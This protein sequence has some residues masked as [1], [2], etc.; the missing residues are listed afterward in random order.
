MHG[1]KVP[2]VKQP[3]NQTLVG[4]L[5]TLDV[6]QSEKSFD[7]NSTTA[8]LGNYIRIDFT[9]ADFSNFNFIL[10]QIFFCNN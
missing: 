3:V 2:S 9:S 1:V 4:N 10:F 5:T 8:H 7:A 6:H